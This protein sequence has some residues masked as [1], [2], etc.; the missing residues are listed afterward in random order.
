MPLRHRLAIT[1]LFALAG[2]QGAAAT[3]GLD[4]SF[5]TA[6]VVTLGP[7]PTS[8]HAMG[9]IYALISQADGKIIVAGRAV[10]PAGSGKWLAAIGRLKADATWD[11][12]FADNGLFILPAGS[13]SAPDGGR[14]KNV[15]LFSDGSILASGGALDGFGPYNYFGCT[16]L[17]KLD[18]SG[19]LDTSFGPNNS[20]NFCFAFALPEYD[21]IVHFDG[22]AIDADDTFYLTTPQ[23]NRNTGA[24]AR[25]D[26]AGAL[27][28]T[29]GFLG[30]APLPGIYANLIRL[31]PG[32]TP[33]VAGT[34]VSGP[35]QPQSVASAHLDLAG[36]LDTGY[37]IEGVFTSTPT[38]TYLGPV[39]AALDSQNRLLI[40]DDDYDNVA[41]NKPNRLIRVT[42][43]GTAD[44]MFNNNGQQPGYPGFAELIVSGDPNADYLVSA[45]PLPDGHI[46]AVGNAG[47]VSAGDGQTDL[48]LLRLNDD[49]SYDASFGDTNHPGWASLNIAG[50][51]SSNTSAQALTVDPSGRVLIAAYLAPD[52]GGHYCGALL[53][54]IPDR[55]FNGG[56]DA[57][58]SFPACP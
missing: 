14:L 57:P 3:N 47:Y 5:G 18:S 52:I 20:G 26:Q 6:G 48:A 13:L 8:N 31:F 36:N 27:V 55:L 7:T 49:A 34:I 9:L 21:S 33:V 50:T 39:W 35:S 4:A 12:S 25:F 40:T 43:A 11:T 44:V 32:G 38:P 51:G 16:L 56:F 46:L 23:T 17:I 45:Q 42:A 29:F 30:I 2:T 37:G 41:G 22:I 10:D 58:L 15:G 53:R 1:M 28:P 54:I 24:V 19:A